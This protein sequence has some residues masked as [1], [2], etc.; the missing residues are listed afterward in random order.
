MSA[1]SGTIYRELLEHALAKGWR[2]VDLANLVSATGG[3]WV[4]LRHDVD[5]SV[6][7]AA[8]MAEI[9]ASVGVQATF[10]L[11]LRSEAYNLLSSRSAEHVERIRSSGQRIG[12]HLP[13]ANAEKTSEAEARAWVQSEYELLQRVV[14]DA[15][16]MFAWHNPTIPWLAKFGALEVPGLLNAYH[17]RLTK[18]CLYRSDSNLRNSPAD[19]AAIFDRSDVARLHWL[20]HP[21]NWVAGGRDMADILVGTMGHVIR[22]CEF[23]FLQNSMYSRKMPN[24]MPAE[25]L[26]S[27]SHSWRKHAKPAA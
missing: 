14:P 19:F 5:Y 24:G 20:I 22:A 11:L 21:F 12:L 3:R 13:C 6:A 15:E 8:D 4:S 10:F 7:M 1:L 25:V 27:F 23:E 18:D 9:N 2:F 26:E 16:P 17:P